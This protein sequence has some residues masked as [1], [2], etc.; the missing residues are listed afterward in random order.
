MD[1]EERLKRLIEEGS[2]IKASNNGMQPMYQSS[3]N[4][5]RGAYS[6]W[7]VHSEQVL[8][9]IDSTSMYTKGFIDVTGRRATHITVA[10]G[11]GVL[12]NILADLQAGHLQ[13]LPTAPAALHLLMNLFERFHDVARQLRKR[14]DSRATLD[15][16]DEYDVQDLLHAL[17]LLHFQDIRAEDPMPSHAGASSRTDFVLKDEKIVIEVKKTRQGLDA[18][19]LG[20]ELIIDSKRYQAH[21]DCETL[22]CFVYDSEGRIANPRGVENDLNQE[23]PLRVR[24]LIR[25]V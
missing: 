21:P 9:Q 18:R 8:H 10:S 6:A 2:A 14:H 7:R 19:K 12:R 16:N 20:E 4:V 1:F 22:V 23:T 25:P 13:Q 11:L 3:D 24:V 5:D 15:V 17:L